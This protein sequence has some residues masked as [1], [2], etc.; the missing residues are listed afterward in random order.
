[1]HIREKLVLIVTAS[2]LLTAVP[3]AVLVYNYAQDKVLATESLELEKST[4]RISNAAKER[5]LQ[6][7][8]KLVSLAKILEADLTRP[9]QPDEIN[10]FYQVMKKDSDGVWRNRKSDYDGSNESGIFLP[11]NKMESDK[12]K[13]LHMRIKHMMDSFGAAASRPLENVWYLSPHRSEIIFDRTFPEFVFDQQADN[14]YTQTPWVTYTSPQLNPSR[15]L[16]FTPPLFDPV[17]KVWM[18]SAIYPL[19]VNGEWLGSLGEDMQLSA[20]L[21]AMFA[22]NAK[23]QGTEHFL[24]DANGNYVL[25]GPWQ[26]QFE[27]K[28]EFTD[29]DLSA[30]PALVEALKSPA[31]TMPHALKNI[32]TM[33]DKDY[34]TIVTLLEPLGWKYFR[35][36]PVKEVMAP[37]KQL[38]YTLGAMLLLVAGLTGV[39]ISIVAGSNITKRIKLLSETMKAYANDHSRRIFGKTGS[40]DEISEVAQV[41]N[42]M[43]EDLEQSAIGQKIAEDALKEAEEMTRFALEGAG[44]GVWDWRVAENK[45]KFSKRWKEMIGYAE[46]EIKDDFEA[47]ESRIHPEDQE[48]VL[49]EVQKYFENKTS[50]YMV[51]FRLQCKDGSYKWILARGMAVNRGVDGVPLRMI[52]THADIDERKQA[53]EKLAESE[54][55]LS[56]I[57]NSEPECIKIVNAQGY[58][59]EMNPAGLA[60]TEADS[61]AQVVGKPVE[62][63][64]APEHRQAFNMMH[65]RVIKGKSEVLEFEVLGLKG[66]RRWLETHAVPMQEKNG[67]FVHLAVSRDITE[68]KQ[69]EQQLRI[70]AIAFESQEG[71]MVTDASNIILR[72]NHAFTVITGYSAEEAIGNTPNLLNSGRQDKAFYAKMW[73]SINGT[74]VWEGEIWNRRKNGDVYPEHLAIAAVKDNSGNVTNYVATITDI[75]MSKAA[76][77]EIESLAFYDPLTK[78]PNRRLLLD[79]LQQALASSTR[80]GQ[81]GALLFLDLDHFKTLNDTLGHDVGDLL[82]RQVAERLQSCVREGDTVARLGGDEFVVLLEDLSKH[83]VEA[84][85][86]TELVGEKILDV[87]KQLYQLGSHEHYSTTSIG[88]TLFNDHDMDVDG[89]LRQADIAMYQAKSEGRN[90]LRFYDAKMQEAI[91]LRVDLE[92]ELRKAIE[93]KQFMLHYQVQVDSSGHPLGA[94][95]LIRWQHPERGM[96][97]PF[98]FIPLAEDTGLIVQIGQWV[99]ETACAQL[100][101]WQGS[102]QT[103]HLTL[104]VNISAKQFHQ[105]DFTEQVKSVLEKHDINPAMLKLELTESILLSNVDV[106]IDTMSELKN[107]GIRFSLDD[108]GTGYSSLQYLKLLP[109]YQLKIDQSFVRDIVDD[110]NDQAII[111]TIIAMA[112]T[113]NLNVIAEGVETEQQQMLLLNNGCNTYQGYLFSKP[114]PIDAFEALIKDLLH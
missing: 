11:P 24:I 39:I 28:G 53:E 50:V 62:D 92:K 19:Y 87:L 63:L 112:H 67:E 108:F 51:E 68:R 61:L 4:L 114:V 29:F 33:Q 89:L 88:A 10:T 40:H 96:V 8:P 30:E 110:L 91:T 43:A 13:I 41:F 16:R 5:F 71:M 60:L 82:L 107:I 42:E 95:A 23:Y 6:S 21:E 18:V 52:G 72:V 85:T 75:T 22:N 31:T 2:I 105:A 69:A 46:D 36:V 100:K 56:T 64:I 93:Q 37:T 109:L 34:I 20:V 76:S 80:S 102:T 111:R 74:G 32:V 55:R 14:D 35:M 25:A 81:M 86:Q 1:M 84:A 49:E 27:F 73:E 3:G 98:H 83:I 57:F 97:S 9:I 103:K 12:Q 48:Q 90:A 45:L 15:G 94:E 77:E 113:L 104:S 7:A 66:G 99:L 101:V 17:P 106:I 78:L 65:Q 59:L 47:F 54:A 38:F 58:L 70:A 44:D 79:R 26:S